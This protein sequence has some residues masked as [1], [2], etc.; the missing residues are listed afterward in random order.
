MFF[1]LPTRY[2]LTLVSLGASTLAS[3][4]HTPLSAAPLLLA[5]QGASDYRIVIDAQAPAPVERAALEL[6][7][8]FLRCLDVRLA[9][10]HSAE[11]GSLRPEDKVIVL[12]EN[13]YTRAL[14]FDLKGRRRGSC[15]LRTVGNNLI[16]A[17]EDTSGDP[18]NP[19]LKVSTGTWTGVARFCQ[20]Y[21][22]MRWYL[23]GEDW[24]HAPR[25]D[26]LLLPETA[27]IL[28]PAFAE[29][30][31]AVPY[32]S[33]DPKDPAR[34]R[35]RVAEH[36]LWLRRNGGGAGMR[37]NDKHAVAD[38]MKPYVR[39]NRYVGN[40]EWVALYQGRRMIPRRPEDF[41]HWY[42]F[43]LCTSHTEVRRIVVEYV[44]AYFS[45]HPED[46][47][48]SISMSDGD[49]Y[50]ECA[51][52]RAQDVP[53]RKAKTERFLDFFLHVA[54]EVR[55]RCPGKAVSAYIY[56][57]YVDPPVK[58]VVLP[59]NLI[60]LHVQNATA[61]MPA[62]DRAA[63]HDRMRDWSRLGGRMQYYSWPVA[64]GFFSLPLTS[65]DWIVEHI[66]SL[67]KQGY[68]GYNSLWY[69]AAH[70]RQPDLYLWAQ[71]LW[72][73]SLSSGILMEEF[74]TDLYGPAAPAVR[75][76]YR[77]LADDVSSSNE[78]VALER[79]PGDDAVAK[80][81]QRILA[82]YRPLLCHARELL[83]KAQAAGKANAAIVRRLSVLR[84]NFRL[85]EMIVHALE[86]GRRLDEGSASDAEKRE[87]RELRDTYAA[88]VNAHGNTDV[89]D[90]REATYVPAYGRK[91]LTRHLLGRTV[92]Q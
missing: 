71:L 70:A 31:L 85:V 30:R 46:E 92:Q 61:Y 23:P 55:V 56:A 9:L 25:K 74:F 8:A 7:S 47:F 10:E 37:G 6:Q 60:L 2:L 50:C 77:L 1:S 44:V 43:H 40:P 4:L 35:R 83:E 62:S 66:R 5:D 14:A 86:L 65:A 12:G 17:G 57:Q 28:E 72:N 33:Y 19:D 84:D 87:L 16:I 15:A 11:T 13:S 67:H 22:G 48:C 82:Y 38:I 51:S 89:M 32:V 88:F 79:D 81:E 54:N 73:P 36:M 29:R 80:F 26:R 42:R 45:A 39:D 75:D 90:L 34:A 63:I 68:E 59:D 69:G 58:A 41:K 24:V 78:Q 3:L 53:D 91:D 76:Y 21:L 64:H 52:C 18:L 49:R 27:T 20:D